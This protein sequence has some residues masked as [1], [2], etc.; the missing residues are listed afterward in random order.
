L[1]PPRTS[2]W[3]S[4]PPYS[5][6]ASLLQHPRVLAPRYGDH[7]LRPCA[8]E[9]YPPRRVCR[10]QH[11]RRQETGQP[12]DAHALQRPC[13]HNIV[14]DGLLPNTTN[15]STST[16]NRNTNASTKDNVHLKTHSRT[17]IGASFSITSKNPHPGLSRTSQ[18]AGFNF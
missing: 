12:R 18:K 6:T 5:N 16:S 1:N 4:Y 17:Q 7:F 14:N 10:L 9:C 13:S 3:P 15:T 8:L 2:P 11:L